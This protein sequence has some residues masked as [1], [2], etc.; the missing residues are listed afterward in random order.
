MNQP[1]GLIHALLLQR[2]AYVNLQLIRNHQKGFL[3][4]ISS[5]PVK[6]SSIY[7]RLLVLFDVLEF[8]SRLL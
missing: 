7:F 8:L 6:I 5:I 1:T 3:D 2:L 4:R